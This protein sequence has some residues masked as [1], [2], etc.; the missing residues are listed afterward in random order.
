MNL[1]DRVAAVGIATK[2]QETSKEVFKIAEE[3]T[4]YAKTQVALKCL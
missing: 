3:E 4:E 1:D 2:F